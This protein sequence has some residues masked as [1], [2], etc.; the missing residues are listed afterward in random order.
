MAAGLRIFLALRLG[1]E[2]LLVAAGAGCELFF[3]ALD[4]FLTWFC[5]DRSAGHEP[6]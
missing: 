6:M 3:F 4:S 1:E 2:E 5:L